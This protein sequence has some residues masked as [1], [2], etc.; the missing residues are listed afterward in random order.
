MVMGNLEQQICDRLINSCSV[1]TA[2]LFK[3]CQLQII[4]VQGNSALL[5]RCPNAWTEDQI[6]GFIIGKLGN[7]LH[8]FGID[9]VVID[10]GEEMKTYYQWDVTNFVFKGYFIDGDLDKLAIV[11]IP[12]DE[13]IMDIL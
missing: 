1:Q 2:E 12:D 4:V 9:Q 7:T 8:G 5:I 6:R 11:P 3:F 10:D 13:D